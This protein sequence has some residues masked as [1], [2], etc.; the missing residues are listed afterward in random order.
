MIRI[1]SHT[2]SEELF[3]SSTFTSVKLNY[4][5]EI[6][7]IRALLVKANSDRFGKSKCFDG[8]SSLSKALNFVFFKFLTV[9]NFVAQIVDTRKC[10]SKITLLY[11]LQ[12]P[13]PVRLHMLGIFK[14]I[15]DLNSSLDFQCLFQGGDGFAKPQ[16]LLAGQSF[17]SQSF[18][19]IRLDS[20]ARLAV[21]DALK[22]I[23]GVV[24]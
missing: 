12:I 16:N 11:G 17:S 15:S 6:P 10:L 14:L 19:E 21:G 4:S 8:V 7:E 24:V 9:G 22:E 20:Y 2:F 23:T 13:F 1:K 3:G 18:D 5:L